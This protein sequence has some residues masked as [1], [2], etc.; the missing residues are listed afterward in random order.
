MSLGRRSECNY[1]VELNVEWKSENPY[2]IKRGSRNV[3]GRG[4]N[5]S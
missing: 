5:T 1:I 3:R 4:F 2:G